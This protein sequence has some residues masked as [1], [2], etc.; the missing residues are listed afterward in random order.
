MSLDPS[1]LEHN[2]ILKA[3]MDAQ[4]YCVGAILD[5]GCGDRPYSAIMG[6]HAS[7]YLGT[8]IS[9]D[10]TPP[11]DVCSDSLNLP[12][13]DESFDTVASTQVIEHVKNPFIMMREVARVLRPGGHV[14]I[15]APQVWP[16]HEEP[17]DFFR[18]TRYALELLA[19]EEGLEIVYVK[20]RGGAIAALGQMCGTLLYDRFGKRQFQRAIVK[21]VCVPLLLGCK[22]LDGLLF[23]PKLTLG[24][25]MVARK[26]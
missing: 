21:L 17:H 19:R 9:L 22:V 8:D 25:I 15:T 23:M 5:L 3:L 10:H 12:F 14:V 7:S 24:Y 20:E 18:Y 26:P 16:L 13:K 2:S 11:P 6:R 4:S 1:H